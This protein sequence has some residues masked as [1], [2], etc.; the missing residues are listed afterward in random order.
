VTTALPQEPPSA[1]RSVPLL[2]ELGD[3]PWASTVYVISPIAQRPNRAP[4]TR[5]N[6][7][8]LPHSS[9]ALPHLGGER[10]PRRA[11]LIRYPSAA[12]RSRPQRSVRTSSL[13]PTTRSTNAK[14]WP[15]LRQ[16]CTRVVAP[17]GERVQQPCPSGSG[18]GHF[19]QG[20]EQLDRLPELGQV[21][22][23]PRAKLQVLFERR[24]LGVAPP[25][26]RHDISRRGS[27]PSV[28]RVRAGSRGGVPSPSGGLPGR[29]LPCRLPGRLEEGDQ[30]IG[31]GH[32]C[33]HRREVA[34][35]REF[36]DLRIGDVL[37]DVP[38][39]IGEP[40]AE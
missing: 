7:S 3:G 6:R 39:R 18:Q 33:Q 30:L 19:R 34:D 20:T 22:I 9:G 11:R 35:P 27:S 17:V 4:D 25:A 15:A 5:G 23:A 1:G 10:R 16:W 24:P 40:G 21:V 14:G 8:R 12:R 31:D 38:S 29:L 26:E 37:G 32:G 36:V 28:H 13:R 2:K